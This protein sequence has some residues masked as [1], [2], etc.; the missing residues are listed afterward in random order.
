MLLNFPGK[1]IL[2]IK[3]N[4][5]QDRLIKN[6]PNFGNFMIKWYKGKKIGKL[7]KCTKILMS[8]LT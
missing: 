3:L 6:V 2:L 8:Y 1:Q 4:Q 7:M 5:V